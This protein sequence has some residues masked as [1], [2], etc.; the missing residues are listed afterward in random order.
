MSQLGLLWAYGI[1][2]AVPH[3]LQQADLKPGVCRVLAILPPLA[4]CLYT[5]ALVPWVSDY[6][7]QERTSAVQMGLRRPGAWGAWLL[8]RSHT[9]GLFSPFSPTPGPP[10]GDHWMRYDVAF[11]V[12]SELQRL[13]GGWQRGRGSGVRRAHTATPPLSAPNRSSQRPCLAPKAARSMPPFAQRGFIHGLRPAMDRGARSAAAEHLHAAGADARQRLRPPCT[14]STPPTHHSSNRPRAPPPCHL[15]PQLIA[16]AA[17]RG[18][19]VRPGLTTLQ[20]TL[21]FLLPVHPRSPRWG[22]WGFRRG[23]GDD[24]AA[25]CGNGRQKQQQQQQQQQQQPRRPP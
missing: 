20:R 9:L 10:A 15:P 13:Q 25:A 2:S 6:V 4:L 19:L 22:E 18:P 16:Y 14:R 7:V 24:T 21:L 3:A 17:N 8:S 1:L 11:V 23:E 5:P 12:Q